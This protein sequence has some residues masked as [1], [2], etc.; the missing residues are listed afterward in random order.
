MHIR[1]H[2]RVFRKD[3][4]SR[5]LHVGRYSAHPDEMQVRISFGSGN[6]PATENVYAFAPVTIADAN[7]K[8]CRG[9]QP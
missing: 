1:S 4:L 2:C 5:G 9:W 6:S 3:S 8:A 7:D